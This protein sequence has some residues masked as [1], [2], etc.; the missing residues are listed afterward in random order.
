[1]H[2]LKS[3]AIAKGNEPLRPS[4]LNELV[5]LLCC[6]MTKEMRQNGPL[7]WFGEHLS[8]NHSVP[9]LS[10]VLPLWPVLLRPQ[11]NVHRDNL[12]MPC[13]G[14][15]HGVLI[16]ASD[17]LDV[18]VWE[19]HRNSLCIC[20]FDTWKVWVLAYRGLLLAKEK[21]KLMNNFFISSQVWHQS[22]VVEYSK[23]SNGLL[24]LPCFSSSAPYSSR[25]IAS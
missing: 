10:P 25:W 12:V 9:T 11:P 19:V 15:F 6:T 23:P 7:M 20:A 5:R 21:G 16:S 2:F 24:F 1:M 8:A 18:Q 14:W 22:P 3:S 4:C 13:C 17:F